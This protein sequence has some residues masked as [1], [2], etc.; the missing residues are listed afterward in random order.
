MTKKST[1]LQAALRSLDETQGKPPASLQ[2]RFKRFAVRGEARLWPGEAITNPPSPITVQMRDFS[3]GGAGLLSN[4]PVT[5]GCFWQMQLVDGDLSI[6]AL[7]TFC[8]YCREVADGAYL[9]GVEFGVEASIL[10]ALGITAKEL[11]EGDQAE[12]Q[13]PLNGDF[14]DPGSLL[15][16]DS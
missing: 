14:V 16:D 10:L 13:R 15:E 5:R 11:I 1:S 8:R 2:R 6:T 3:R 7:P 4:E 9:I 12:N